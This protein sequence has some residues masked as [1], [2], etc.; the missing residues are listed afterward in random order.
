MSVTYVRG[1]RTWSPHQ[2]REYRSEQCSDSK[3]Y[4]PQEWPLLAF[5]KGVSVLRNARDRAQEMKKTET[6]GTS[7]ASLEHDQDSLTSL[8]V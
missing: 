4:I 1:A 7:A 6:L 8:D 3:P 5:G 2:Q